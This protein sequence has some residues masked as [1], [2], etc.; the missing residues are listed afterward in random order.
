MQG[1]AEECERREFEELERE[2]T[3]DDLVFSWQMGFDAR[4]QQEKKLEQE[5]GEKEEEEKRKK[6]CVL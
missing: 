4:V 5:N 3:D 6:K 1:E 2:W